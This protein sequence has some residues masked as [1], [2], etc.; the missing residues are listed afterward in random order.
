MNGFSKQGDL[1]FLNANEFLG[2]II[3]VLIGLVMAL[4]LQSS[5]A[6]ITTTLAALATGAIDLSEAI[7]MVIGQNVGAVGITVI[8]VIG[9]SVSAKRTV[10]VNV[11]FNLVTA[12]LAFLYW[13]LYLSIF[14]SNI[15][16]YSMGCLDYFGLIPYCI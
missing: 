6:A 9:A 14:I 2:Q 7:Y 3:L 16:F 10:A 15:L 12:I 13:L 4:L 11:V 8:S 1:S 5:S